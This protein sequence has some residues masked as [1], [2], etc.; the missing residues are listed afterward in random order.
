MIHEVSSMDIRKNF[1]ELLN[2]V[3]YLKDSVIIKKAGKPIAVL[4]DVDLFNKL[5]S[6]Q[7]TDKIIAKDD[8]K[9]PAKEF[10]ETAEL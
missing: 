6:M 1:G 3:K 10:K 7:D 5:G 9:L 2:Q 4:I 8:T